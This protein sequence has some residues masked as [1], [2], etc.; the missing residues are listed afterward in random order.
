MAAAD[1]LLQYSRHVVRTIGDD[2]QEHRQV[3]TGNAFDASRDE[4]FE[5]LH[6]GNLAQRISVVL[7]RL[8][9][10]VD[11]RAVVMPRPVCLHGWR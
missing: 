10:C 6:A 3:D 5:R 8:V 4:K 9:P 2:A 7:R 11:E 1:G